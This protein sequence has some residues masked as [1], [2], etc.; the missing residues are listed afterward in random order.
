M[1]T[2]YSLHQ[3]VSKD[4]HPFSPEKY[5]R[6]KYGD[7]SIAREFGLALAEG[8]ISAHGSLMLEQEDIYILPSP[9]HSI[10]TAS[11]FLTRF[12]KDMLNL[13]LYEHGRKTMVETKIHRNHT[14]V[15]DY[16]NLDFHDRIKLIANDTYRIDTRAIDGRFCIL[17]DD[18][19]I[20]GSHEL[21]VERI[22]Q[23]N[24]VKGHFVFVYFAELI[25]KDIHPNIENHYNYFSMK[26]LDD[27]TGLILQREF[28]F[29]TRLIKFLLKL[30]TH[31]LQHILDALPMEKS[32]EIFYLSISNNY[33]QIEEYRGNIDLLRQHLGQL[34]SDKLSASLS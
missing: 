29:N 21:T 13:F 32:G 7:L 1:K 22:L 3:I 12:F 19:R 4:V 9:Y 30:D 25:N 5:S 23:E 15:T 27:F 24:D 28:Q 26:E 10:P 2:K 20:T 8:F 16:G 14:Y 11:N 6:F 34:E 31:A 18:I 17:V 33:H